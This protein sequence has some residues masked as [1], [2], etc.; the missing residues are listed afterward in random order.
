MQL[1]NRNWSTS[2][3]EQPEVEWP[4][5]LPQALE[6]DAESYLVNRRRFEKREPDF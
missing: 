2:E 4:T 6:L 3:L 1:G 5:I